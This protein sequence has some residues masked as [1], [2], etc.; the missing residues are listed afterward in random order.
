MHDTPTQEIHSNF[1]Y[2]SVTFYCNN[3]NV[4]FPSSVMETYARYMA[5]TSLYSGYIFIS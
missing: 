3:L 4:S 1:F 2:I 5:T